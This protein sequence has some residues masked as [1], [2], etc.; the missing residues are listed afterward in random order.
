MAIPGD[1]VHF[2]YLGG[3]KPK[4]SVKKQE[5]S[6]PN[7]KPPE[8]NMASARPK[9]T[10]TAQQL[11]MTPSYAQEGGGTTFVLKEK[12]IL[13]EIPGSQ[14]SSSALDSIQFP[15]LNS[16]TPTFIG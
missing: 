7:I 15:G 13:K 11:A 3:Y 6:S 5:K 16:T 9:V 2:E 4:T 8:L 12:I 14:P 10:D 1:P